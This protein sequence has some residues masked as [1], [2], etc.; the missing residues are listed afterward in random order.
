MFKD[1]THKTT[2]YSFKFEVLIQKKVDQQ[3]I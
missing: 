3:F 2:Q 1:K